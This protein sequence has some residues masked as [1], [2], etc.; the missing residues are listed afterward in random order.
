V[1]VDASLADQSKIRESFQECGA[2]FRALT[3]EDESFRVVETPCK[4]IDVF[5]VVVPHRDVVPVQL[6]EAVKCPERVEVVV[7]DGDSHQSIPPLAGERTSRIASVRVEVD[8]GVDLTW[9]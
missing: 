8:A 6:A 9:L 7:E 1:R 3:D 5:G 4:L 2:D